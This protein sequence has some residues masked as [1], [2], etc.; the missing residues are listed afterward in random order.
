MSITKRAD[1][2]LS[3]HLI[4]IV[5]CL[6]EALSETESN[7]LNYL[8]VRSSAEQLEMVTLE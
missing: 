5:P 7:I 8:A 3:P 4:V 6:L 1:R 2:R